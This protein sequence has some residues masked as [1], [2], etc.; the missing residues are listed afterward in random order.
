MEASSSG[1]RQ[2]EFLSTH[3]SP[4]SRVGDIQKN[5]PKALEYYRA[6]GGKV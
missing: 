4:G 3:P 6:A 2:P 1:A 5:L